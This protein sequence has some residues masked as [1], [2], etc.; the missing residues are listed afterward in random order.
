MKTVFALAFVATALLGQ[1]PGNPPCAD[2]SQKLTPAAVAAVPP[3]LAAL[4]KG[5]IEN[6]MPVGMLIALGCEACAAEA[7]Q[8]ALAQGSTPED[9]EHALRTVEV[10]HKLGCFTEKFGPD[11]AARMERPLAA[12]WNALHQAVAAR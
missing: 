5:R 3:E 2:C 1:A 9:L 4:P 12:A 11:A 8:Y 7:V 6:L 10:V